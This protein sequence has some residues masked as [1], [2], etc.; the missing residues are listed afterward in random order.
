MHTGAGLALN[1]RELVAGACHDPEPEPEP[2]AVV[3]RRHA[4]AVVC[5][6]D[7]DAV[8][9]CRHAEVNT[10]VFGPF[11]SIA[12]GMQHDVADCLRDR[13]LD[14]GHIDAKTLNRCGNVMP[15]LRT[16]RRRRRQTQFEQTLGLG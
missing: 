10:P 6:Q 7:A 11:L 9:V 12:I 3:S 16:A 1:D 14:R 15:G 13:E 4:D 8:G 5:D 2:R